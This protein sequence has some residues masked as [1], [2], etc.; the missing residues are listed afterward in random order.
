MV[1]NSQK[2]VE[3]LEKCLGKKVVNTTQ[4]LI[5]YKTA[6]MLWK[7]RNEQVVQDKD[8]TLSINHIAS[9]A[10]IHA[11]AILTILK[12]GKRQQEWVEHFGLYNFM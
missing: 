3:L 4:T 2:I 9:L 10:K 5:L 7:C 6:F 11:L 12:V 1:T 8:R